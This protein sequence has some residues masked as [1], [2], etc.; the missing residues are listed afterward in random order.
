MTV[1]LDAT[2]PGERVVIMDF[3]GGASVQMRLTA[4]GLRRGDTA[5]VV[6][7]HKNGQVVIAL[8]QKRYSLGRGLSRK[9][10]V[11]PVVSPTKG[12]RADKTKQG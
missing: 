7:N 5:E 12:L 3:C 11:Q 10:L 1:T 2:T 4:M 6:T 9:I 8:D